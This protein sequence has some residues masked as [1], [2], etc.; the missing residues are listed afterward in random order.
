MSKKLDHPKD[1]N[2]PMGWKPDRAEPMGREPDMI[3]LRLR[4]PPGS[5]LKDREGLTIRSTIDPGTILEM[6]IPSEP[7]DS[8]VVEGIKRMLSPTL[9]EAALI[10]ITRLGTLEALGRLVD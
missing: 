2:D 6:L 3:V 8:G 4:V 9:A 7:M 1:P 5:M 10:E